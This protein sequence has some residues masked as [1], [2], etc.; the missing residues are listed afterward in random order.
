MAEYA[1][2]AFEEILPYIQHLGHHLEY[3]SSYLTLMAL[4]NVASIC[5]VSTSLAFSSGTKPVDT[6]ALAASI[7]A[8]LK[9]QR[10]EKALRKI[11]PHAGFHVDN[12]HSSRYVNAK[13][14]L[15]DYN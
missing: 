7:S 12:D 4:P 5:C 1:N 3:K 6:L 9:Q 11:P 2:A 10:R 15:L 14:P 13:R 8:N